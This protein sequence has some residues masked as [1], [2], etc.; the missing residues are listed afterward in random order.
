MKETV[1]AAPRRKGAL[2][3]G[4]AHQRVGRRSLFPTWARCQTARLIGRGWG[5]GEA[6]VSF[7]KV[8]ACVVFSIL[9]AKRFVHIEAGG[10]FDPRN[11]TTLEFCPVTYS[12]HL[13][14]RMRR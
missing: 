10:G 6:G 14:I 2:S 3:G 9:R 8:F 12:P 1:A 4:A 5:L 13:V 7:Y 11:C